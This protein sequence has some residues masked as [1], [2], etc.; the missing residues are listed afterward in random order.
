MR[1]AKCLE[2]PEG[3]VQTHTYTWPR[4]KWPTQPHW[5]LWQEALADTVLQD[6]GRLELFDHLI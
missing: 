2:W 5:E 6:T 4:T 3:L 1:A